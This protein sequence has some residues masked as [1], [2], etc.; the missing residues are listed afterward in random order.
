MDRRASLIAALALT[1]LAGAAVAPRMIKL[2]GANAATPTASSAATAELVAPGGAALGIATLAESPRGVLI[3]LQASGLPPGR[4]GMHVHAKGDCGDAKFERAG[5]HLHAEATSV[6]GLL[7]AAATDTGDLPNVTVAAD[8]RL[9]AEVFSTFVTLGNDGE[10]ARL[11]D[12][13]GAA[14]IVHANPDDHASQPI[15]GAGARIACAV[16]KPTR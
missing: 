14:L 15:G 4:H 3:R 10:R 5:G 7:N 11:L 16:I 8:G 12:A 6:H 2:S 1:A 9:D 13:D